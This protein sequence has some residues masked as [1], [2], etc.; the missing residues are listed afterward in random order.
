MVYLSTLDIC[1]AHRVPPK[2]RRSSVSRITSYLTDYCY[3]RG[4]KVE[5]DVRGIR[6][7][8]EDVV[9]KFLERHK[10]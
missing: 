3:R 8:R 9:N 7:F 5:H 6:V 4:I 2:E 10:P 1:H